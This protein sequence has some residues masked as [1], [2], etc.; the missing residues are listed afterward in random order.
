[1]IPVYAGI[2]LGGTKILAVI[3]DAEGKVLASEEQ[4]TEASRG[5]EAIIRTMAEM[6]ERLVKEDYSLQGAGVA[7]AG[8]LDPVTGTVEYAGNLGWSNVPLGGELQRLLGVKVTVDNDASAA[9]FGEWKAGAGIGTQHCVFIT[10]S[11]GIGSGIVCD[12]K[13]MR[14]RDAS[15]AELGHITIDWQGRSC[16]CGNIGCVEMYASG[17]A[18]GRQAREAA[19]AD[20]VRGARLLALAGGDAAG[21]NSRHVGEAAAQGDGLALEV[22]RTAGR[23]LGA[24]LVSTIH[25]ANPEVI[26]L[27]GGA[28]RIGEPLLGPMREYIEAHTIGSMRRGVSFVAP[29]LGVQAGAIGAALMLS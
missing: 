20:P 1:M 26:I 25:I 9:A 10:I 29:K 8:T 7:T 13:L 18:I 5:H 6:V 4:A 27:G 22:L 17:T 19:A 2:D 28:S 15:A 3:V 23:A 16:P 14:G 21:I 12:G 11:T 24:G